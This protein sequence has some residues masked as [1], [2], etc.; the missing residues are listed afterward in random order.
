[1]KILAI[2]C[3]PKK[4][5]NTTILLSEA[6]KGA[7]QDGAEVE[8]Y[9][10]AGKTIAPCDACR[11]CGNKGVCHIED[12]MQGL[13][14]KLLEANGIIFG[15]PVYFYNMASQCK[16]VMDRTIAL[17]HTEK[18]LANKVGGIVVVAGSLGNIDAIKDLYFFFVSRR[19]LAANYVAAY[20]MAPGDVKDLEKSMRAAYDLG[21]QMVRLAEMH[22]E[23]PSESPL[24]PFAYGTHTR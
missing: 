8:L 17:Y 15:T 18:N 13:Y 22:F 14:D 12:D 1:M 19:M 10:V 2:S 21:R 4:Q 23:Y 16:V 11:S 24:L 3:S 9:S 20:A 5:G 6:L 7:Q